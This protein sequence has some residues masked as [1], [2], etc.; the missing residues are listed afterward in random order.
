MSHPIISLIAIAVMLQGCGATLTGGHVSNP[1]SAPKGLRYRVVSPYE[2]KIY[3]IDGKTVKIVGTEIIAL[4]VPGTMREINYQGA[5]ARSYEFTVHL[6]ENGTLE[7]VSLEAKGAAQA[8]AS[9]AVVEQTVKTFR[10]REEQRH[11]DVK[12]KQKLDRENALLEA[13]KKNRE[14]KRELGE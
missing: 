7:D 5:L 10:E 11:S 12:E 14:L 13:K 3:H 2:V 9:A 1:S 8:A 4:P 6:R